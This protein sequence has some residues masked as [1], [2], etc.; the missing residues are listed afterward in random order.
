MSDP[1]LLVHG[2]CH[3]A[4]CWDGVVAELRARGQTVRAIDLPGHGDDPTPVGQVT[5]DAYA[6]AILSAIDRPVTLVGHSMAGY[7]ITLAAERAPEKIA[8]LIYLCAYVPAP[9]Q[10]LGDMRRA[11]P[12]QPLRPAIRVA[13]DGL[14]F[15]VDPALAGGIFYNDCPAG[16]Q[17]AAIA[18]LCPQAIAP[19]ETVVE[20]TAR[21]QGVPRH[22]ILCSDDH[23]IPP[24]Y[25]AVMSAGFPPGHVTRLPSGHSPFLSMPVPLADRLIA[26][27]TGASGG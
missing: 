20:T 18:R 12:R 17:A 2:S 11:G 26:I 10:T 3:G 24:E 27:A 22:D 7:P 8:R 19:Q 1:I 21:W 13:G 23:T 4:W 5:L 25:Q 14:S 9:G 16:V 6:D 15:T